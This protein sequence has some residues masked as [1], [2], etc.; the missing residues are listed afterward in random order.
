MVLVFF[1]A[2]N[3]L[4]FEE[5]VVGEHFVDSAGEGKDVSI[6]KVLV[7]DEHLGWTVLSGLDVFGEMLVDETGVAQI[8]DF[9]EE[10]IIEFDTHTLPV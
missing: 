4:G 7:A 1:Y 8:C 6:W 5:E 3:F 9:E 2:W 10:L